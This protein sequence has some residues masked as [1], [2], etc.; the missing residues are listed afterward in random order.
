MSRGEIYPGWR[1]FIE[2]QTPTMASMCRIK[3]ILYQG[4]TKYQDVDIIDTYD[5][6][7][8]LILDG[9]IQSAEI[10]E[11]IYHES[12]VHVPLLTHPNPRNVVIVGGGE[13]STLREVLK[14]S[15]IESATMVDIDEE[16]VNICKKYMKGFHKNSFNDKRA[17]LVFYDGRRYLAKQKDGSID[18]IIVD[19]TDPIEEGPSYLLFTDEF[20]KIIKRKLKNDG[21]FVTQATSTFYSA[22]CFTSIYKTVKANFKIAVAYSAYVGSY[23]SDWG[24]VIG[25]KKYNP[26]S[27]S[28]KLLQKRI[29]ERN[30]KELKFYTPNIHESLFNQA[31]WV[32][33]RNKDKANLITDNNP[34]FMPI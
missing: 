23:N 33:E 1:W 2:W 17:S 14:H 7:I 27:V 13:G 12:L 22:N 30:I 31:E 24:F 32:F 6:G 16:L 18:I 26:K 15:C 29:N 28:T 10:D 5:Y 9:K 25:S 21:I 11:F 3:K 19:V 34:V 8:C 20:Y 4:K